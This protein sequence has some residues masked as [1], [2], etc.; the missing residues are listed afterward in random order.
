MKILR[1]ICRHRA[2]AQASLVSDLVELNE[3]GEIVIN[4]DCSTAS[5]KYVTYAKVN[6]NI[7]QVGMKIRQIGVL[8][9]QEGRH[10]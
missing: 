2:S 7:K 4:S 10:G 8:Q 9:L 1:N 3:R 5:G 6:T